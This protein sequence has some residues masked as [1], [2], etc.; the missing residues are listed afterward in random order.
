MRETKTVK[1]VFIFSSNPLLGH[2]IEVLLCQ[3]ASLDIVGIETDLDCAMERITALQPD[4]VIVDASDSDATR[5]LL[6]MRILKGLGPCVVGL[7]LQDNNIWIYHGEC[8]TVRDVSDF[9]RAI[10]SE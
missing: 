8:R 2:G 5:A 4:L 1:R 3:E 10:C 9:V 7:N 6:M